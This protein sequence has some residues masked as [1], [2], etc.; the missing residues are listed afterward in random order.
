VIT[1]PR[2]RIRPKRPGRFHHGDLREALVLAATRAVEKLGH[3]DVSLR[4]I[5]EQLGVSQPAVYRHFE[6]REALLAEVAGRTWIVFETALQNAG[7]GARDPFE[8]A[9][10]I[11]RA[12][13]RWAHQ[14]PQL[15]RLLSSRLPAE[16]R[17]GPLP[18]L[19]RERYFH[20][21][22]GA[23]PIDEPMLAD[24]FRASW[25]MSHGLATFVVERV[26]Q[27]VDTDDARLVAA[28]GA[29]ACFVEML[30]AKWGRAR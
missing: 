11:A 1:S 9:G 6:S 27:R 14:N 2:K 26:F 13:V 22:G 23:V 5:A 21:I 15:F 30:R 19:P 24:A 25:A 20:G 16:Q 8:A 29:I 3:L 12:Y 18:A 28:D 17:D 4:P 10:A 7:R